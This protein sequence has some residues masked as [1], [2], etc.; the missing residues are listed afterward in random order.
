MSWDVCPRP[1]CALKPK[2]TYTHA[3]REGSRAR[4]YV[5]PCGCRFTTVEVLS[6]VGSR[7]GRRKVPIRV[8]MDLIRG[9]RR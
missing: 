6:H 5:C 4:R 8:P 1:T 7:S 2:L 9:R 3:L